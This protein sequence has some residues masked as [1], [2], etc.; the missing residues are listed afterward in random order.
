MFLRFLRLG[1]RSTFVGSLL[2]A[3]IL[4]PVYGTGEETGVATDQFNTI[5][6]AKVEA[7][8]SRLWASITCWCIFIAFILRDLWIEW[9]EYADRRRKYLAKGDTDAKPDFCYTCMIEN[10]PKKLQSNAEL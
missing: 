9:N 7:G 10:V 2:G 3:L 8:S 6:L 5:T 1:A 4:I